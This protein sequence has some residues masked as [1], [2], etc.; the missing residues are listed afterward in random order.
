MSIKFTGSASSAYKKINEITENK[1]CLILASQKNSLRANKER[2]LYFSEN[3]HISKNS[4]NNYF[5]AIKDLTTKLTHFYPELLYL[6]SHSICPKTTHGGEYGSNSSEEH[7]LCS[8]HLHQQ[9]ISAPPAS[10]RTS[11]F[12]EMNVGM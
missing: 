4:S 11:S 3:N 8:G 10:L 2:S 1:N 12:R 5:P 6:R 9:I 7:L